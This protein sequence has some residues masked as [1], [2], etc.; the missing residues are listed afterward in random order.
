MCVSVGCEWRREKTKR[1][2]TNRKVRP[3][4]TE[5]DHVTEEEAGWPVAAREVIFILV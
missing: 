3:P 2:A 1:K 5:N 4:L